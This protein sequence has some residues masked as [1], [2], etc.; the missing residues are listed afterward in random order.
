M[1]K[2]QITGARI[3]AMCT[4]VPSERFDN[5]KDTTEFTKDEVRKVTAMAGVSAR[6]VADDATCSSD[7]CEV[8]ANRALEMAGWQRESVDALIMVTQTPDYIMPSTSCVLHD[9]FQIT[10]FC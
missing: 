9:R 7:L 8:A 4:S 6:R 5:L 1:A 3:A 10:I 2:I